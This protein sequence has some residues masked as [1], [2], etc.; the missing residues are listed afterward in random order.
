VSPRLKKIVLFLVAASVLLLFVLFRRDKD[1]A[2]DFGVTI[3]AT[4]ERTFPAGTIH[5]SAR[6]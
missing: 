2:V 5:L 1:R 3:E 6:V 4:S